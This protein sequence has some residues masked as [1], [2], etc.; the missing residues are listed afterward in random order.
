MNWRK[1]KRNKKESPNRLSFLSIE[2][3]ERDRN[4]NEEQSSEEICLP[5]SSITVDARF[6]HG[7]YKVFLVDDERAAI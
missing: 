4:M 3:H 6:M 1:R 5:D 7:R 2:K